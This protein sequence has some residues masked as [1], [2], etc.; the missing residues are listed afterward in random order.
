MKNPHSNVQRV[1][2]GFEGDLKCTQEIVNRVI[3]ESQKVAISISSH[4]S[5]V[6]HFTNSII[7]SNQN[8]HD[9]GSSL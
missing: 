1:P 9:M 8:Q 5:A 3:S 4:I 2:M 7:L 6:V